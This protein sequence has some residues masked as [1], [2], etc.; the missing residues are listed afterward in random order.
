M[1][2]I[3][4]L[5]VIKSQNDSSSR[6][7]ASDVS[8]R[9]PFWFESAKIELSEAFILEIFRNDTTKGLNKV[10]VSEY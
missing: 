7:I 4:Y 2:F 8:F 10:T 3:N 9:H 1:I 5:L 6:L